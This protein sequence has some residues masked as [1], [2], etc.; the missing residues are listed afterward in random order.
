MRSR[1]KEENNTQKQNRNSQ[2]QTK[3]RDERERE[4]EGGEEAKR[5]SQRGSRAELKRRA[6]R[7]HVVIFRKKSP[8][9]WP[10]APLV[11]CAHKANDESWRSWRK[12]ASVDASSNSS[13]SSSDSSS[14]G[15]SKSR[16]AKRAALISSRNSNSNNN[17][18][19]AHSCCCCCNCCCC[20]CC[21]CDRLTTRLADILAA[22]SHSK[23]ERERERVRRESA[24]WRASLLLAS[25]EAEKPLWKINFAMLRRRRVVDVDDVDSAVAALLWVRSV[26]FICVCVCVWFSFFCVFVADSLILRPNVAH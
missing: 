26:L 6:M 8:Q 5:N 16:L 18:S 11:P 13:W 12:Q 24:R 1:K 2:S 7:R 9:P 20:C 14:S 3:A 23:A 21:Y 22:R 15:S 25:R 4:R 10:M 19:K 17:I